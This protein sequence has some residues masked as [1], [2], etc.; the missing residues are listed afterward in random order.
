[1]PQWLMTGCWWRPAVAASGSGDFC[2]GV[3]H[4]HVEAAFAQGAHEAGA[5]E[6]V[7]EVGYDFLEVGGVADRVF[8]R[9][10]WPTG[11]GLVAAA[12]NAN[13]QM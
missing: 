3:V 9:V 7:A 13:A 11:P 12:T 5:F 6:G 10:A 8:D 4:D 1:M 2:A